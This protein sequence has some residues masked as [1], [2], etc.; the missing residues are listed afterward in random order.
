MN[1]LHD[2]V[3]GDLSYEYG[4]IKR[5]NIK[6]FGLPIDIQLTI[7]CD[8]G[9]AIENAQRSAFALFDA[10][11][12]LY[13]QHAEVAIFNHYLDVCDEC[14]AQFGSEFADKLAP[15]ITTPGQIKPL[16]SPTQIIFQQSF[17]S[18]K[19]IVGLLFN[20]SWAPEL[21]LAVKFIDELI[22]EVGPQDIVL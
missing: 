22:V 7:P 5:Y 6:F 3:I 18:G 4:W 15:I 9:A 19:R 16:V 12:D 13:L 10:N 1:T 8:E 17:T 11:K 2:D 20:C 14:R 21:G